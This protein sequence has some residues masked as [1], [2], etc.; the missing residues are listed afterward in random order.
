MIS[1]SINWELRSNQRTTARNHR[2]DGSVIM[3]KSF[4]YFIT[5]SSSL[6]FSFPFP[7]N[8]FLGGGVHSKGN[9]GFVVKLWQI[10]LGVSSGKVGKLL[11]PDGLLT[12]PESGATSRALMERAWA[13]ISIALA[14]LSEL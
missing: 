2:L 1:I 12:S 14:P 13:V 5:L 11:P 8:C 10:E 6:I 9:P 4:L 3:A 7:C